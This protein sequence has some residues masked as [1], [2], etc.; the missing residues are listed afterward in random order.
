MVRECEGVFLIENGMK[1][2]GALAALGVS[3]QVLI[4]LTEGLGIVE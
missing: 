1:V 4:A 2:L 3:N